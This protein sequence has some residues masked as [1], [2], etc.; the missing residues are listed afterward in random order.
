MTAKA[1]PHRF[2]DLFS[3]FGRIA[4]R[5]MFGGEGIYADDLM[6]GLVVEDRIYFKV[7]DTTRATYAGEQCE[8]FTYMKEG[9]RTSLSYYA[10][11]DRLYDEPE[12]LAEWARRAYAVARAKAKAKPKKKK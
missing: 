9:K 12:E 7:D 6:F 10:I 5:R 4:L 1:D 2:D 3:E 11:P 8:P